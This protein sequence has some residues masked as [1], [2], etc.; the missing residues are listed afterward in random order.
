MRIKPNGTF[1]AFLDAVREMQ[2]RYELPLVDMP[3]DAVLGAVSPED[4]YHLEELIAGDGLPG[5]DDG[6]PTLYEEY[7]DLHGGDD[8]DHGQFD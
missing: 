5:E 7:Q 6:Q 1:F 2:E 8:W 3:I 4:R